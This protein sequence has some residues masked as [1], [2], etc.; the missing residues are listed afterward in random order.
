MAAHHGRLEAVRRL[1]LDFDADTSVRCDDNHHSPICYAVHNGRVDVTDFFLEYVRTNEGENGRNLLL[2]HH[3]CPCTDGC[4]LM[5]RTILSGQLPVV[6][7]IAEK[8]GKKYFSDV[9]W[10]YKEKGIINETSALHV[11]AGGGKL[12][13]VKW[14]CEQGTSV[15]LVLPASKY[16]PLSMDDDTQAKLSVVKYLIEQQHADCQFI[17]STGQT[18]AQRLVMP[19]F[20]RI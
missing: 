14:L 2:N 13:I 17:T 18:A 15:D 19:K 4:P 20:R 11:V 10:E 3:P 12:D 9:F 8:E 5:Y 1:V 7:Y 6:Q 16:T